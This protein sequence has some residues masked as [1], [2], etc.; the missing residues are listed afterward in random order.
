L[1]HKKDLPFRAQQFYQTQRYLRLHN[2][3]DLATTLQVGHLQVAEALCDFH[4]LM[5][6]TQILLFLRGGQR[7]CQTSVA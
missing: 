4:L 3:R 1:I 2:L 6:N 7:P 5:D